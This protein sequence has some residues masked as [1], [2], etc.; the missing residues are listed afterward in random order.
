[1]MGGRTMKRIKNFALVVL[2]ISAIS[3]SKVQDFPENQKAPVQSLTATIS[4]D[5]ATK[6][7]FVGGVFMW[8]KNDNMVVR[9]NNANGFS[10]FTYKGDD[11]AG[12]A[13]FS[14]ASEDVIVYGNNSFAYYPA[15]VNTTGTTKY[16]CEE[17]GSLKLVLKD[18]YTWFDGNVEAPMLAKVES[19][20][21]LEF[22]HL[23]GVLKLTFKN[24]PP[25]AAKVVVTAPVTD[26]T[27]LGEG[28]KTYKICRTMNKTINWETAQGGF[29]TETP[30][31]QA[32]AHTDEYSITENIASATAAQR[33]SD[34]GLV[35]YVPLPVGPETDGSGKHIYPRLEV[36]MTFAD[37]TMVPG[38]G[39]YAENVII[40]RG[41]IKPMPVRTLTKYSVSV[42]AG[43][44]GQKAP[45][46]EGKFNNV[47]GLVRKADGNL[48]LM[49]SAGN[50][51]RSLRFISVT[52]GSFTTFRDNSKL[53]DPWHGSIKGD[54][55]YFSD[56]SKGK[57]FSM[58]LTAGT[59]SVTEEKT[60]LSQAMDVKFDASGNAYVLLRDTGVY[61]YEGGIGGTQ[62]VYAP[63]SS[64]GGTGVTLLSMGFDPAGNLIVG[65]SASTATN[66]N[67]FKIYKVDAEK[68]VTCIAGTGVKANNY[69]E[70][71]D[72]AARNAVFTSN[73]QGIAFDAA[74]NVY[75]TDNVAIRKISVSS[76][77]NYEG[78]V[79]TT[80][81][82]GGSSYTTAVG[83]MASFASLQDI[84]FSSDYST[85]Y[86]S[87]Q[88]RGTVR[89][90]IIE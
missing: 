47:R 68:N 14:N 78:A 77:G 61:K 76:P 54:Y 9:S 8:K 43:I 44:D 58:D 63:L 57:V 5:D 31:V 49:E 26:A 67:G 3:C 10:T 18:S 74:G 69:S 2:G 88:S 46:A 20:Q 36:R 11:T 17:D 25:K 73:L 82:G 52:D 39:F 80:I 34:D 79:V 53:G 1:M 65:A 75:V 24:V 60:G 12:S 89:K 50:S 66:T 38:A 59:K 84:V 51:K 30:Y 27:L 19:G 90:I 4:D 48:V 13:T 16:P 22:K 62:S 56:K 83:A 70:I 35:V 55:L 28:K 23:G 29:G 6:T 85:I 71:V 40:E 81:M 41:H 42:L 7:A 33:A 45:D 37:G 87:D 86:V 32:Y 15:K 64:F 72:G 21:P